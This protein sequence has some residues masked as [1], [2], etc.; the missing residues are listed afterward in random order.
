MA[1]AAPTT[2][3]QLRSLVTA[4]GRVELTLTEQPVPAPADDQVVVRVEAAPI[5]PSDVGVLLAGADPATARPTGTPDAPALTLDLAPELVAA[6]AGRVGEPLV[7]GN[8]GAGTVVAAGSSPAA[9]VLLGRTVAVYGGG[10]YADYRLIEA[11]RC[12]ELPEGTTA[13]EGAACFVNPLTA[14]GMVETMRMEGYTGL[15]HTAAA[16]NLGQMLL[17]LCRQDGIPLVNV[18]RRPEQ[19]ALL[20]EQGAEHVCDTSQASFDDDLAAAIDA[21]GAML[22]FDATGGGELASRILT[23]MERVAAARAET[24]NRYGSSTPKQV[25]LYGSLDRSPTVLRRRYGAVWGIGGWLLTPFLE[26]IGTDAADALRR[27]VAAEVR[28]TFA[29]TYGASLPLGRALDPAELATYAR[30]ATGAKHLVVPTA[31]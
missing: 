26:R 13:A 14:L 12:L 31:G 6:V 2:G 25:Y 15:V 4:E 22:A 27:R 3:R 24:Y 9:Q 18:V 23:V 5:N 1:S 30:A 17:R 10:M 7:A 11:D 21:T 28:T 16:S 29:S 8:E 20:R 19:V